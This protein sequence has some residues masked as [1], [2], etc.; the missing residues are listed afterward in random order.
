MELLPNDLIVSLW[1]EMQIF[2]LEALPILTSHHDG[3]LP[4]RIKH[5]QTLLYLSTEPDETHDRGGF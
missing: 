4:T 3:K 2:N 5:L 1:T